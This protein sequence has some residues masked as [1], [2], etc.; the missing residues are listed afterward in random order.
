MVVAARLCCTWGCGDHDVDPNFCCRDDPQW[1]K[2]RDCTGSGGKKH[3]FGGWEFPLC[4]VN[5][6]REHPVHLAVFK[7]FVDCCGGRISNGNGKVS[8]IIHLLYSGGIN[9]QPAALMDAFKIIGAA[10]FYHINDDNS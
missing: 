10:I 6:L 3:R 1:Q 8:P 5:W 7:L 2:E 4:P 9:E